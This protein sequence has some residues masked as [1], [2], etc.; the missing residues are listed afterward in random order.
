MQFITILIFISNLFAQEKTVSKYISRPLDYYEKAYQV[1]VQNDSIQKEYELIKNYFINEYKDDFQSDKIEERFANLSSELKN[2]SGANE[3]LNNGEESIATFASIYSHFITRSGIFV[4]DGSLGPLDS[5]FSMQNYLQAN[6]LENTCTKFYA[7][8]VAGQGIQTLNLNWQST[9]PYP[10]IGSAQIVDLYSTIGNIYSDDQCTNVF[11]SHNDPFGVQT[12]WL[13]V[14]D[15]APSTAFYLKVPA[16][17]YSITGVIQYNPG[18]FQLDLNVNPNTIAP[19]APTITLATATGTDSVEIQWL[20]STQGTPTPS[21]TLEYQIYNS[22][23]SWNSTPLS[24]SPQVVAG[25]TANTNYSFRVIATNSVGS[26]TSNQVQAQTQP[27]V[28]NTYEGVEI[29]DMYQ[30]NGVVLSGNPV[31]QFSFT[32]DQD[33]NKCVQVRVR[34][35]S[36]NNQAV[37]PAADTQVNLTTTTSMPALYKWETTPGFNDS[38]TYTSTQN[39]NRAAGSIINNTSNPL[40]I[41]SSTSV[42]PPGGRYF[43]VDRSVAGTFDIHGEIPGLSPP[44]NVFDL[45]VVISPPTPTPPSAPTLNA[46]TST[47]GTSVDL[48]WSPS[49][50]GYPA[51]TYTA[52]YQ[53]GTSTNW[54]SPVTISTSPATI[55]GLTAATSYNFRINASNASGSAYSQIVNVT[56]ASGSGVLPNAPVITAVYAFNPTS[57][58]ISWNKSTVGTLPITYA[59]EYQLSG[60]SN[61]VSVAANSDVYSTVSGLTAGQQY[62]FRIIASNSAGSTPSAPSSLTTMPSI[63][64]NVPKYDRIFIVVFENE[65]PTGSISGFFNTLKSMGTNFT[66]FHEV[67]SPSQENYISMISAYEP[68]N[69]SN[70]YPSPG[71]H[72]YAPLANSTNCDGD[73]YCKIEKDTRGIPQHLG[74]LFDI[75]NAGATTSS[76][77]YRI[78]AELLPSNACTSDPSS[79]GRYVRKHNP[80]I[81]FE[82]MRNP[83]TIFP[84]SASPRVFQ[85]RCNDRIVNSTQLNADVASASTFRK[86]SI[87]IPDTVNDGHDNGMAVA[88][89]WFVGKFGQTTPGGTNWDT[90]IY[91]PAFINGTLFITTF[92]ENDHS[93]V[94]G[95]IYTTFYGRM[96]SGA[97]DPT[98]PH[99]VSGIKMPLVNAGYV[100]ATNYSH[101][102]LVRLIE[103]SFNLGQ[104]PPAP[105]VASTSL[106]NGGTLLPRFDSTEL[107]HI[108]N[109]QCPNSTATNCL[110][111][112]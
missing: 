29:E 85:S 94:D 73:A 110:F 97:D 3:F 2:V 18:T 77:D 62:L 86:L 52:E 67:A 102:S 38:A 26:A 109:D 16:G 22:G 41:S 36:V 108:W 81:I 32:A 23:T 64:T 49:A 30:L 6:V 13:V 70:A 1:T 101:Y 42:N 72:N 100:S 28:V 111:R 87:Y 74:D 63:S 12:Q 7:S 61:W 55:N 103:D 89:S 20:Q 31:S 96:N 99:Y 66:N 83:F 11:P 78:Y 90:S 59:V 10:L 25:L 46:A 4:S 76:G 68:A 21:Y 33:A 27:V 65:D 47:S 56:T 39:C 112:Q 43:Y 95:L 50:T 24:S 98:A 79:S 106:P 54:S 104:L 14:N 5:G 15:V 107:N 71:L 34:Y 40:V 51:P 35:I 17:N 37:A 92:D 82:N 93:D 45:H 105:A 80:F 88:E 19:N 48:N 57:V 9:W 75:A 53:V 91:N 58:S 69:V 84:N 60:T 44:H 8:Y